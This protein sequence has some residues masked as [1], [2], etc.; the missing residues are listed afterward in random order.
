MSI[1]YSKQGL[2]II[3]YQGFSFFFSFLSLFLTV[4]HSRLFPDVYKISIYTQISFHLLCV[5]TYNLYRFNYLFDLQL[6][7]VSVQN[8]SVYLVIATISGHID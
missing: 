5:S 4:D 1:M 2:T 6:C 8:T 7:I 3:A